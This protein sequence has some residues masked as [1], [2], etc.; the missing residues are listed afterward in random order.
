MSHL[1]RSQNISPRMRAFTF[2]KLLKLIEM[3]DI[4]PLSLRSSLQEDILWKAKQ[5][6]V[7][8]TV[9]N[10]EGALVIAPLA[11]G[12]VMYEKIVCSNNLLPWLAI[13]TH[14]QASDASHAINHSSTFTTNYLQST[15]QDRAYSYEYFSE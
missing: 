6:L 10:G 5:V 8:G 13:Y 4:M 1:L 14:H 2:E 11:T 15:K 12:E 7:E 3:F 9:R